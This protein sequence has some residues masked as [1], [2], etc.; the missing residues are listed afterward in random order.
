MDGVCY[1]IHGLKRGMKLNAEK[2]LFTGSGVP[3]G[4]KIVRPID[5]ASVGSSMG[6]LVRVSTLNLNN[7]KTALVHRSAILVNILTD[8]RVIVNSCDEN[9]FGEDVKM[10][11]KITQKQKYL[12]HDEKAEIALKYQNGMSMTAIAGE[13]GCHYTTVGRVLRQNGVKIRD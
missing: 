6:H 1:Y 12:T 13:Y 7:L 2:G 11:R 10:V 8:E 9:P 5:K 3:L 4:H